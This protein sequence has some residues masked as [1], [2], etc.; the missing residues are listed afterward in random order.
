MKFFVFKHSYG[1]RNGSEE[2]WWEPWHRTHH[3]APEPMEAESLDTLIDSLNYDG[4]YSIFKLDEDD[5]HVEVQV[6]IVT[7]TERQVIR[8]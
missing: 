3:L 6:N 5:S 2:T 4:L 1:W 8:R 7:K